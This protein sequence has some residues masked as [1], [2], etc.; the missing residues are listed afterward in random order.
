MMRHNIVQTI[1]ILHSG[2]KAPGN[3]E[4]RNQG[5]RDRRILLASLV[6]W[7]PRKA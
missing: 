2:S 5:L 1:S 7:V 6:F 3:G 4:S